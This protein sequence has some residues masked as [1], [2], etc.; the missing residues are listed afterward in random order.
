MLPIRTG[1]VGIW[2]WRRLE[3][4]LHIIYR[5]QEQ[6]SASEMTCIVSSGALNPTH[7]LTQ[8]QIIEN[9]DDVLFYVAS[10]T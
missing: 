1:E 5:S 6:N 2:C 7:S 3:E 9:D 4:H 8:E 10:I